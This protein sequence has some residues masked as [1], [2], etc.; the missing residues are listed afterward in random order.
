MEEEKWFDQYGML[1]DRSIENGYRSGNAPWYSAL[2]SAIVG[3]D[4]YMKNL[5]YIRLT[6][7]F[8]I[9]SKP[10]NSIRYPNNNNPDSHDNMIAHIFYGVV[11]SDELKEGKWYF[12]GY[13]HDTHTW[14]ECFKD[15]Y[16]IVKDHGI[17]PHRNIWW[18]EG[19]DA[20]GKLANRLP[21]WLRWYA[22]RELKYLPFLY[23][24]LFVSWIKPN[25]NKDV[26]Q[27]NNVS[28]KIQCWFILKTTGSKVFHK[29]FDIKKLT[30]I[31]F[32]YEDYP[33]RRILNGH[34]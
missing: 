16:R 13:K 30:N 22:S 34:D 31:Y 7:H 3:D 5:Y 18:K 17:S 9:G 11:D 6:R 15:I 25:F 12:N 26:R 23:L 19:Y 21:M 33:I 27:T 28:A 14:L 4:Y 29:L 20:I 1:H 2:Y 8:V 10:F 32:D 24:H